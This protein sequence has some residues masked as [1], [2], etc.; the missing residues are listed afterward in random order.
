VYVA[1]RYN[2]KIRKI[3]SAGIVSTL[4]GSGTAGNF[5]GPPGTAQFW[6]PTG[7]AVDATGNVYVADSRNGLIRKVTPAGNVSTLASMSTRC[8]AIDAAGNIYATEA[9]GWFGCNIRKI[10]PTG[11]ISTLAPAGFPD[12]IAVDAS[13]NVYVTDPTGNLI[14]KIT[15]AGV[16][17]IV[18]GVYTAGY[19]DGA[20][21]MAQ[22]SWPSGI[23]VNASGIIYVADKHNHRIRQI[24]Q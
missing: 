10:S 15:P 21:F 9:T 12:D 3:S 22:F 19:L 18:A 14:S 1:D 24:I 2:N 8:V 23:A 11:E 5:N 16:M 20:G 17:S 6:E 7:I 13:G 4:A